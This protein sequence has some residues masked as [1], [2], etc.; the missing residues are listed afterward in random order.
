MTETQWLIIGTYAVVFLGGMAIGAMSMAI[1]ATKL[2]KRNSE[3]DIMELNH[4]MHMLAPGRP[5]HKSV[6]EGEEWK[7]KCVHGNSIM[8][9]CVQCTEQNKGK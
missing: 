6:E 7:V 4:L 5:R 9:E 1:Q 8:T 2:F 3:Q